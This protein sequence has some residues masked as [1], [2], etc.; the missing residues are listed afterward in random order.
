ME[1]C[2][3]KLMFVIWGRL[4]YETDDCDIGKIAI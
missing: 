4:L 3:M 2:Y 1:D